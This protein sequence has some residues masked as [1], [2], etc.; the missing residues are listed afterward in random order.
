MS[1][2]PGAARAAE[3]AAEEQATIERAVVASGRGLHS[4]R[5]AT[6]RLEP[7]TSGGRMIHTEDGSSFAAHVR[8]AS[9]DVRATRLGLDG[10]G[11][12]V[13]TVEHVLAALSALRIDHVVLRVEGGELPVFDGSALPFVELIARAGRQPVATAS[14]GQSP[15]VLHAPVEVRDGDGF[16]RA[17]PA[18]AFGFACTID[19]AHPSIGRQSIRCERLSPGHFAEQIA[20]ARTFGFLQDLEALRAADLA[21][22]ADL[23]N[24]L[25]F[26][27]KGPRNA[28][29]LRFPDE[30]VRHKAIDLI[31]DLALL[32]APLE[33]YVTAHKAGHRLHQAL[34]RE[35]EAR[36]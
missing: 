24:T 17:E 21:G 6:L 35:I 33:A 9:G 26:D 30:C 18:P 12:S 13:S 23:E 29:P 2:K 4:G 1:G 20:P 36:R 22:G 16:V 34:V 5:P 27:E 25:V 3:G 15:V 28:G 31:G 19:F 14:A 32:D 7:A 8:F 10:R 11:P